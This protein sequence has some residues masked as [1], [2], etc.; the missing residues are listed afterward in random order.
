M[1]WKDP[2]NPSNESY[3]RYCM[4]FVLSSFIFRW[5]NRHV[6]LKQ[7][8][9]FVEYFCVMLRLYEDQDHHIELQNHLCSQQL[10]GTSY[11]GG[12]SFLSFNISLHKTCGGLEWETW[13]LDILPVMKGGKL[14]LTCKHSRYACL[15]LVYIHQ[16][17]M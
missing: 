16:S 4:K 12:H 1:D 9:L 5:Q 8:L 15:K 17:T 7:R 2:E 6:K 3:K 13:L 11:I 14:V 10:I